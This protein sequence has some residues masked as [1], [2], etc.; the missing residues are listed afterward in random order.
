MKFS[1]SKTSSSSYSSHCVYS[2]H[3]E[4]VAQRYTIYIRVANYRVQTPIVDVT[5]IYKSKKEK[6]RACY[7]SERYDTTT[8]YEIVRTTKLIKKDC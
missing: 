5:G 8:V 4:N 3:S 7:F 6:K 2:V 1:L